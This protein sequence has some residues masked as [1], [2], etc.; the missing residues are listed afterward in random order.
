MKLWT[1]VTHLM[2][3]QKRRNLMKIEADDV[4]SQAMKPER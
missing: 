3:D 2:I 1:D 4:G